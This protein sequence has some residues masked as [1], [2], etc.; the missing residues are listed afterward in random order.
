MIPNIVVDNIVEK[1]IEALILSGDQDWVS[2]AFKAEEW[3][4]RK[5]S[6]KNIIFVQA[7][8]Y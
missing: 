8:I 5:Q 1:H 7:V 2:G 4:K 3:D 6:V